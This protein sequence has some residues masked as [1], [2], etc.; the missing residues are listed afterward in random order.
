MNGYVESNVTF[1]EPLPSKPEN[2]TFTPLKKS[3]CSPSLRPFTV[4]SNSVFLSLTFLSFSES[5]LYL[6]VHFTLSPFLRFLL[7][8][9]SN[10]I[11][12]L[13]LPS[14][15]VLRSAFLICFA[16]AK[17]SALSKA[18]VRVFLSSEKYLLT[19]DDLSSGS[20]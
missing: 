2:S 9:F 8:F 11:L 18:F 5:S 19:F 10:L 15:S 20:A 1:A 6:T 12:I 4:T 13:K 3:I 17:S 7:A 14:L 16:S